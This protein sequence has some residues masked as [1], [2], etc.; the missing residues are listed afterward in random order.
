MILPTH[1]DRPPFRARAVDPTRPGLAIPH[2]EFDLHDLIGAVIHS[3]RPADAGIP[4]RARGPL[5]LP[6]DLE[7]TH[8][9]PSCGW[10][11]PLTI[12]AHGTEQIHAVLTLASDQQFSVEVACID[13]MCGGQQTLTCERLMD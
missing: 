11:L 6:I 12:G 2:R 5:L 1:S 9:K 10:R 13:D 7:V 4:T 8:I 3:G